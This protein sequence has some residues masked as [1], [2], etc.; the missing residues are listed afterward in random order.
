MALKLIEVPPEISTSAPNQ[1]NHHDFMLAPHPIFP[2]TDVARFAD[3]VAADP[4]AFT[5]ARVFTPST[6]WANQA[7]TQ[8]LFA[9]ETD[10]LQTC[11]W[12]MLPSRHGAGRALLYAAQPCVRSAPAIS[13][14]PNLS[15]RT[16]SARLCALDLRRH[17]CVACCA[18]TRFL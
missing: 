9:L 5:F 17:R 12:S 11:K 8:P 3:A 14:D 7:Q 18:P 6:N 16:T 10:V 15:A 2:S 1:H 4:A 13:S